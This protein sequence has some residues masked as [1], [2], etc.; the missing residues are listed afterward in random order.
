MNSLIVILAVM[1]LKDSVVGQEFDNI[2]EFTLRHL[3]LSNVDEAG[4]TYANDSVCGPEA[5]PENTGLRGLVLY[6]AYKYLKGCVNVILYDREFEEQSRKLHF[7]LKDLFAAF[8]GDYVNGQISNDIKINDDFLVPQKNRC[9]HY[10]LFISNLGWTTKLVGRQTVSKVI[11]VTLSS[12]WKIEDYLQRADARKIINL[13]IISHVSKQDLLFGL[14][15]GS[16]LSDFTNLYTHNLLTDPVGSS[17][18]K[19]LTSWRCGKLSRELNL[20]P[21]K[22]SKGFN[23]KQF[24]ISASEQPPFTFRRRISL[25]EDSNDSQLWDGVEIRLLRLLASFLNYTIEINEPKMLI[26]KRKGPSEVVIEDIVEGLA[27]IGS[28]GVYVTNQRLSEIWL[29]AQHTTDCAAF[30]TK[31]STSL[32]R[33]RAILGPFQLSVWITLTICYLVA[34]IPLTFADSHSLKPLIR[35][36][37]LIEDMF[38][39]VFGTFTNLFTF[40]EKKSWTKST[41]NASRLLIGW[42]WAFSIIVTACYTGSIVSF[43]TL[44]VFPDVIDHVDQLVKMNFR[45]GTLSTAGWDTWFNNSEHEKTKWLLRDIELV[46]TA[47]QGLK[48]VS[49]SFYL[50]MFRP[51]AF[52]A[53]RAQ[54]EYIVQANYT[55]SRRREKLHISKDCFV[56]F[57]VS[58]VF[59]RKAIYADKFNEYILRIQQT[60]LMGK[61]LNEFKWEVERSSTGKLLQAGTGRP[62]REVVPLQRKLTLDDTQGMYLLLGAGYLIATVALGGEVIT[63]SYKKRKSRAPNDRKS[64]QAG[65]WQT[66]KSGALRSLVSFLRKRDDVVHD[67]SEDADYNRYGRERFDSASSGKDIGRRVLGTPRVSRSYLDSLFGEE[68]KHGDSTSENDIHVIDCEVE[69]PLEKAEYDSI[70]SLPWALGS[71]LFYRKNHTRINTC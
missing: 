14:E 47:T 57:G 67:V 58:F 45:V 46:P 50:P 27:E 40:T 62:L 41:K 1:L 32:P 34:I 23:G 38:W 56:P 17:T 33:Y 8:P 13:L 11:V 65:K 2:T 60:G 42:Y 12:R 59:P 37:W 64:P 26:S 49:N 36:P 61:L 28:A 5:N 70:T 63:W 52:L 24:V 30:I 25:D 44:F 51:Y 71:E 69:R 43:I 39:H 9:T 21:K 55:S 7:K 10:L 29:S 4:V 16:I 68:N 18:V 31:A 53:G 20:F 66:Y 3:D 35:N 48:N 22:M 54:M 19:F 6:T 15:E